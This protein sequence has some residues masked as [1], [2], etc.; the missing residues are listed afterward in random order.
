MKKLM[1]LVLFVLGCGSDAGEVTSRDSGPGAAGGL[2]SSPSFGDG[3]PIYQDGGFVFQDGGRTS[4]GGGSTPP[5]SLAPVFTDGGPVYVDGGVVFRDGGASAPTTE[6]Q[7]RDGGVVFQDGGRVVQDGG[8]AVSDNG[9]A[10]EPP[11]EPCQVNLRALGYGSA[12]GAKDTSVVC[13][14]KIVDLRDHWDPVRRNHGRYN[15]WMCSN[16]WAF[17]KDIGHSSIYDA[18]PCSDCDG[19]EMPFGLRFQPKLGPVEWAVDLDPQ[20]VVVLHGRPGRVPMPPN[21]GPPE[22]WERDCCPLAVKGEEVACT[23]FGPAYNIEWGSGGTSLFFGADTSCVRPEQ[24]P[25]AQPPLDPFYRVDVGVGVVWQ[26]D[27]PPARFVSL[28]GEDLIAYSADGTIFHLDTES[29]ATLRTLE[30]G[31]ELAHAFV[32]DGWA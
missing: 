30:V 24:P 4:A 23:E 22:S 1:V 10:I 29:G 8:C 32:V 16:G 27:H 2:V 26:A 11:T 18:R 12:P 28:C 25:P 3:G 20:G 13:K 15:H 17:L 9:G 14:E 21:N 31:S 19:Y 5:C 6:V 7:F